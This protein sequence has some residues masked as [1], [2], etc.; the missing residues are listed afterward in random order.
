MPP[1]YSKE[2]LGIC[3]LKGTPGAEADGLRPQSGHYS[4][5]LYKSVAP[6]TTVMVNQRPRQEYTVPEVTQQPEGQELFARYQQMVAC[7][8]PRSGVSQG[9]PGQARGSPRPESQ[10][11]S[12]GNTLTPCSML[13]LAR[14]VTLEMRVS[15]PVEGSREDS[16][17]VEEGSPGATILA[18]LLSSPLSHPLP[19]ITAVAGACLWMALSFPTAGSGYRPNPCCATTA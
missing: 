3:N 14:S 4:P 19:K 1:R 18:S 2:C 17:P 8:T 5:D 12:R 10:R 15:A 11:R 9:R 6:L 13:S 7:S 16:R